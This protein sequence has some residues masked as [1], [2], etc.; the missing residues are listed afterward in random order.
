M[1]TRPLPLTV[2]FFACVLL[3]TTAVVGCGD[4]VPPATFDAG[5][6]ASIDLDGGLDGGE[7]GMDGN[8]PDGGDGGTDAGFDAGPRCGTS[9]LC[10]TCPDE[11]D[12]CDDDNPCPAGKVC[13]ETGCDDLKRC[14]VTGGGACQDDDDCADPDYTC[15]LEVGRCLRTTPG[16]DDS[17]DCVAGFACE[18][19]TCADR[20]VP[21]ISVS[22]CPH[23]FACRV[24]ADDQR[25]CRRVTRPCDANID[26]QTL[27]VVCGDVE[28]DGPME[29]MA[30]FD[31]N[32]PD[33]VS[34]DN[35]QCLSDVFPVCELT[36][37]GT[38]AI[39]GR[40]GLCATAADCADGFDFECKDLWGDGRSECVLPGGS[41]ADSSTCP[42][43][44]VC[45]SPRISGSPSC[46]GGAAM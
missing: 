26:C 42:Q 21:C 37:E 2:R 16:C 5:R 19:N 31:P 7:G 45:A 38:Q 12:L 9:A 11:E 27:G 3:A 35:S 33:S 41:C 32:E 43:R 22:D 6:D 1:A 13:L 36:E 14:F 28:G 23:G 44:E 15:N 17:N 30:P 4:A 39:C 18:N 25:F 46:V 34:C 20:R 10:P 29:C 40:F 8:S 24:I